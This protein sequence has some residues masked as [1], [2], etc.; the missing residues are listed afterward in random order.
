[1]GRQQLSA[2]PRPQ[3]AP[4]NAWRRL[5]STQR[6]SAEATGAEA[7]TLLSRISDF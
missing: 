4:R 2:R 6:C 3:Q 5:P 1:M 7:G